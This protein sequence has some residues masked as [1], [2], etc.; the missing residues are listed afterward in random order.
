MQ[1]GALEDNH[2]HGALVS[3]GEPVERIVFVNKLDDF[4]HEI[5]HQW[6]EVHGEVDAVGW[7]WLVELLVETAAIIDLSSDLVIMVCNQSV[8]SKWLVHP[9]VDGKD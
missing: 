9:K 6:T 5:F 7:N 8:Q 3:I 1:G 2:F 4:E